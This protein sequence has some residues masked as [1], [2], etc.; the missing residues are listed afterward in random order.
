MRRIINGN[1][2]SWGKRALF[3]HKG[4]QEHPQIA[5]ITLIF[6]FFDPS[7]SA[8]PATQRPCSMKPSRLCDFAMDSKFLLVK[9]PLVA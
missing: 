8:Y 9:A 4:C 3:A 1:A 2:A 7:K 5:Q 6:F